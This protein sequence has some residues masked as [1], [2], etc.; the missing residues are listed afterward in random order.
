MG[1]LLTC[2]GAI[3]HRARCVLTRVR[4]EGAC[5][6]SVVAWAAPNCV[7][8]VPVWVSHWLGTQQ[9]VHFVSDRV[10][11]KGV[12][13]RC[14]STSNVTA[15]RYVALALCVSARVLFASHVRRN[16]IHVSS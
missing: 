3:S 10:C 1:S 4:R 2:L 11:S 15:F 6:P 8:W 7:S 12:T 16:A 14:A 13:C 9:G 5:E